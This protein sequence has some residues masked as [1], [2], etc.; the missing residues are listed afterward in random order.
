MDDFLWW[1]DGIIYQIYPRSFADCNGDG[2]GD[3]PGITAKLDYLADL[4]IDAIWLSP[5]YPTPDWDFG[6]DISD[7]YGD[8]PALRHAGGLRPAGGRS[9]P[10]RHP[11]RAGHG[12]EPHLRPASLVPSNRAPAATTP[13]ATGISGGTSPTTGTAPS[14]APPGSFDPADRAVLPA[15]FPK[16]QPDVNWRNPEVRQ[17]QLDV[18]RFWL[19]RGVD[20]FRLDVFNAYFKHA[21]SARQPAQIWPARLRP[22]APHPR[23]GP[24]GDDAAAERTARPAGFL[25]GAVCRRRDV[26]SHD[27]ERPSAMPARGSC[28]LPFISSMTT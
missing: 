3:L 21:R 27:R 4:G 19:E 2:V 25:P 7:Y 9:P 12:A 11:R 24:A 8:G 13:S 15:L 1:R 17:A 5:F 16:E 22:P 18:F 20:G 28:T 14:A 23:Y 10:P 6:Y 26:H